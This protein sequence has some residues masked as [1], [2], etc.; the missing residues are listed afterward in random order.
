MVSYQK[1]M[2][3]SPSHYAILVVVKSLLSI[4]INWSVTTR[5]YLIFEVINC[6]REH[7]SEINFDIV[8]YTA[9]VWSTRGCHRGGGGATVAWWPGGPVVARLGG[10]D[11]AA[12]A[13]WHA[14]GGDG[15]GTRQLGWEKAVVWGAKPYIVVSHGVEDAGA[16][17]E[18]L[19]IAKVFS[20]MIKKIFPGKNDIKVVSVWRPIHLYRGSPVSTISISTVPGLTRFKNSAR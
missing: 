2:F 11:S 6:Q 18:D 13:W 16:I 7:I 15:G 4:S 17:L 14:G 1:K 20:T 12:V 9:Y 10:G 8:K 3:C 5:Y 19:E